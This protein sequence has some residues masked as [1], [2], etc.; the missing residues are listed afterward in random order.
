M[1]RSSK[2]PQQRGID[3]QG[4]IQKGLEERQ[5]TICCVSHRLYD[6]R[7][8]GAYLPSQPG[9]FITVCEGVPSLIEVKSS[10][11]YPSLAGARS[12]VTQLFDTE[13]VAKM[14]LWIRAG[15]R[16]VVVFEDQKT[17][18]IEVWR[19]DHIAST[20]ITTGEKASTLF[21]VRYLRSQFD[22]AILHILRGAL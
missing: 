14:R 9:D 12:P 5:A 17:R 6:T 4:E 8:A 19:G 22:Q 16:A 20:F 18:E 1:A 21:R 15:A 13:Q 11:K 7:S 3:F 10:D 2:T